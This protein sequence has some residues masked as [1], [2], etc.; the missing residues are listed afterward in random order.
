VPPF[1][2]PTDP[3]RIPAGR[4]GLLTVATAPDGVGRWEQGITFQPN[5]CG[6]PVPLPIVPCDVTPEPM[7]AGAGRPA[8]AEWVPVMLRGFDRCSTLSGDTFE[9]RVARATAQLTATASFQAEQEFS[10]GVASAAGGTANPR[11]TAA[12]GWATTDT[13][14]SAATLPATGLALLEDAAAK[15]MHGQRVT[16]HARPAVVAL[17]DA[18]GLLH[19]EGTLLVTANDNL[20]VSGAG[21]SG[22]QPTGA[23][24]AAGSSW[25]Y[26][27][28]A[29]FSLQSGVEVLGEP[30]ER[31]DLDANTVETWVRRL[32]LVYTSTC[33]R[34][35]AEIDITP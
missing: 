9:A 26:A 21:Y 16:I 12:A 23:A 13:A 25:A 33:C 19:L 28:A 10:D 1:L 31:L 35:A 18:A 3:P 2:N 29:V 5:A 11:L 15:C 14:T 20:V 34:I 24:P 27:T 30:T 4:R 6:V 32:S 22:N 17:W 7:G 8:L